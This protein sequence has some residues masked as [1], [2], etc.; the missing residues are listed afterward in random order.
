MKILFASSSSGSRGGGETYLVYL[1]GALAELGH[2]VGLWVSTHPRMDETAERFAKIGKVVRS[3][4]PNTYDRRARSL[5]AWLD[6]RTARMAAEE[7]ACGRP[8]VIHINKQNLEDGLDLIRGASISRLPTVCTIHLTQTAQYLGAHL[9]KLRDAVARR[10]LGS[11]RGVLV[12][13]LEERR[14]ELEEFVGTGVRT[15][16]IRNG[17]PSFP[18]REREELRAKTRAVL[19]IADGKLL[20]IGVGRLVPQKRP[21]LFLERAEALRARLPE[22][23]F[24]WIGDGPLANEWDERVRARGLEGSVRRAGWQSDVTPFLAAADLL[25]HV[26]AYEGLPLAILE[27]M[28]AGVP[29]AVSENLRAEMLFLNDGNSFTVPEHN[30]TW[31]D[32][33]RE[34]GVITLKGAAAR[35]LV[36][37]EFSYSRMAGEYEALY[38]QVT[39]ARG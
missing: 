7:W 13:V 38:R 28:S 8:D 26:A 19:G 25:L 15:L 6:R 1:G 31:G 32:E 16:A 21:L 11:Y 3:D 4:Y 2:E 10:A 27:A 17:V 5:G 22:A 29:C 18:L 35:T 37:S 23:K 30:D 14:R 12:A 9:A 24:L 20:V 34:P 36:E 39:I 33:L